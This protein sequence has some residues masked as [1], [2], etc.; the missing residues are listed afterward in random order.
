MATLELVNLHC[1]RKQDVS[2]SDEPRLKV[3][4]VPVWNGVMDKG[5]DRNLRPT[6]VEFDDTTKVALEELNG[7]KAKQIGADVTIR[8]S[9]N[10]NTVHFKTSGA[11]YELS[12]EVS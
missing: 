2:G 10:P 8:E 6:S 11:W 5:D 1:H 7:S 9:G 4:G 3:D 12:F